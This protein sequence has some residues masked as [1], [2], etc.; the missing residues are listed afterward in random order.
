MTVSHSGT[1]VNPRHWKQSGFNNRI[2]LKAAE[3]GNLSADRVAFSGCLSPP[4]C[5]LTP[6]SCIYVCHLKGAPP[7]LDYP[8]N[9]LKGSS[10]KA[11]I[12]GGRALTYDFEGIQFSL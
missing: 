7:L 5:V 1:A 10:P 11:V 3:A 4:C 9:L 6:W 12:L 8:S 2:F